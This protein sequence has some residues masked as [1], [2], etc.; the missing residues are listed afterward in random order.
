M[1]SRYGFMLA[2]ILR[3]MRPPSGPN[4]GPSIRIQPFGHTCQAQLI[5]VRSPSAAAVSAPKVCI[6]E[7]VVCAPSRWGR[8][9]SVSSATCIRYPRPRTA[10]RGTP[11]QDHWIGN[12]RRS[13][14]Q[15][16]G[17]RTDSGGLG[18]EPRTGGL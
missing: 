2:Q 1:F 5:T 18:I 13:Q 3:S 4:G 15:N 16:Q 12:D 8:L 17:F 6:I 7:L 11:E 10:A 9:N 14:D